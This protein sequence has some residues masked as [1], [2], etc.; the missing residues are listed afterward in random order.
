M[1]SIETSVRVRYGET[2]Q[3]GILYYGNYALYYEVGRAEWLRSFDMSYKK[4]EAD[5]I[6]MPVVQLESRYLKAAYY[7]DLIQVK[8]I[9]K[10]L[11]GR[12]I[13]LHHELF[14]ESKELINKGMVTLAFL[15]EATSRPCQPPE[16]LMNRL[17]PYF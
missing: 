9:L 16:A 3:M 8:T 1:I 12:L 2:D 6:L 17:K 15:D 7:D 14:N 13:T 10:E 11:P 5:G 4:M